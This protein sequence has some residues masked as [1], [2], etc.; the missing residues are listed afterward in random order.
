MTAEEGGA[1]RLRRL[2]GTVR[3]RVTALAT[4]AVFAVLVAAGTGIAFAQK[5]LLTATLDEAIEQGASSIEAAIVDGRT[6][7]VLG[8]FGD[9][10][11]VAQ[12]VTVGG[13]VVASTPNIAR[14][15]PIVQMPLSA[16]REATRTVRGILNDDAEFRI[17]SRLVN[18]PDGAVA[19]VVAATLDDV[20]E[21]TAVLATSL[22][23]AVPAVTLL[24]ATLIW[25]L[26][27]R[28]L[29]PVESIRTEVAEISGSDLRRRVPQPRGVDEV[30]RLARTMNEMLDRLENSAKAQQR[31]A[32][33]ASHELR[34]PLTRI[35]SELEVDLAH[36]DRS[37]L[38]ATH[39]SVL[40]EA[41]GL[42]RLVDDLLHL[43]RSDAGASGTRRGAVDLDDIVLALAPAL[44]AAGRVT[45]DT[46]GVAAAQVWG[47]AR[48]LARAVGNLADNAARHA[49]S[50][51]IFTVTERADV[52]VL[53]VDDDGPGV[54]VEQR[55]RIFERFA[56]LDESRQG[57]TGGTGLGLAIARDV[58]VRHGGTLAV[59]GEYQLGAR[60]VI[61]LPLG[62]PS[63][64]D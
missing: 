42:E 33:D 11:S 61:T 22:L 51:I 14:R 1:R 53:T 25:L 48:Q 24:L 9:D 50:R 13:E 58:V 59:D 18:G 43:A 2:C 64:G 29:R 56:R 32:A 31:F 35:R 6:P 15:P 38:A 52:A 7:T 27:G 19:V 21:S 41:T 36:P 54:P 30:A 60:F 47:D 37:D 34:S 10:D 62:A 16:R 57:P 17:H 28:T 39:R 12:V 4:V 46:N 5:R 44:R 55:E 63:E 23:V 45:V 49:A 3:F 8:G 40:E 20:R 26:V